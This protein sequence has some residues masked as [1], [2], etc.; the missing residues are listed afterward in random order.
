MTTTSTPAVTTTAIVQFI[1]PDVQI[2][3]AAGTVGF[4]GK[5]PTTAAALPAAATD[6]TSA[7]ALVNAIAV[8][9]KALGL[10]K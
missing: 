5:T 10:A 1:G 6:L 8:Q 3:T 4:L 2:G 7:E 9:L